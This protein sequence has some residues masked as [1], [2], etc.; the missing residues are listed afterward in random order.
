MLFIGI[1]V[2][3]LLG[4]KRFCGVEVLFAL[5]YCVST[6]WW[7]KSALQQTHHITLKTDLSNL[8]CVV[9]LFYFKFPSQ[10][11]HFYRRA[12][13]FEEEEEEQEEEEEE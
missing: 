13:Y 10:F 9:F 8:T 5:Q 1:S 7:Y 6:M 4:N 11:I 3:T 2:F 12:V